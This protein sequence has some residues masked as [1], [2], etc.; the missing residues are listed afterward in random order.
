[1]LEV[2]SPQ[3]LGGNEKTTIMPVDFASY[4]LSSSP[5]GFD[6]YHH[7]SGAPGWFKFCFLLICVDVRIPNIASKMMLK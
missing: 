7:F 4:L 2:E 5:P 3:L 6:M 1:M